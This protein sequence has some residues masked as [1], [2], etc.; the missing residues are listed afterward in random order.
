[1]L[2]VNP[3]FGPTRGQQALPTQIKEQSLLQIKI[4]GAQETSD[5]SSASNERILD[6]LLLSCSYRLQASLSKVWMVSP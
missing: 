2:V 3:C 1:M 6:I 4:R 5:S